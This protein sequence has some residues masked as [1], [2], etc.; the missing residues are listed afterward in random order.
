MA[1]NA[2]VALSGAKGTGK[3]ELA[4]KL[5][6]RLGCPHAS[7][8]SYISAT[9]I[10]TGAEE[11]CPQ[12]L[13]QSGELLARNPDAMVRLVLAHYNWIPETALVFDA[14]RHSEVLSALRREVAPQSVLHVGLRIPEHVRESRLR[15]RNREPFDAGLDRHSTEAQVPAL[16]SAS[17]LILDGTQTQDQLVSD[18]CREL[19][20]W[21]WS[22]TVG[23]GQ[24]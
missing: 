11:P 10:A 16:V 9:L 12:L 17:D 4:A 15:S 18:I 5:A 23:T 24:K 22:T 2:V 13:R 3:T 20:R 14:V 1:V 7:V 6:V 21:P 19:R 8:S